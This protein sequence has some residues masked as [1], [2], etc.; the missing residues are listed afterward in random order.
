MGNVR[1]TISLGNSFRGVTINKRGHL[2]QF[3]SEQEQ[4]LILLLERDPSVVDYVSQ[5]ETLKF[6]EGKSRQRKYTLDFQV[7]RV[8][9]Q[10][11]LH[12]VTIEAR[13]ENEPNPKS[14]NFGLPSLNRGNL[15]QPSIPSS[16]FLN[17]LLIPSFRI[18]RAN[19]N[20]KRSLTR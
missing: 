19:Q 5:P 2:V 17:N 16:Q 8:N 15:N 4:K 1:R 3:E 20:E 11:E 14:G 10:I 12:D 6:Y 9:G 13:R 18:G 7:W